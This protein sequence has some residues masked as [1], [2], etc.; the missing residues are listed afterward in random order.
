MTVILLPRFLAA[1]VISS[2]A[3]D[4]GNPGSWMWIGVSD[5]DALHEEL[6]PKEQAYANHLPTKMD[7]K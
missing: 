1:T 4:Q 6:S 5:V 2:S 3:G 7:A